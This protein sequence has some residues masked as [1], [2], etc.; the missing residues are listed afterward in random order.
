MIADA[1]AAWTTALARDV[2]VPAQHRRTV[3]DRG[4]A[5]TRRLAEALDARD[6]T[7]RETFRRLHATET[8]DDLPAL[9]ERIY[10]AFKDIMP[11]KGLGC[12]LF[13]GDGTTVETVWANSEL[14]PLQLAAGRLHAL[15]DSSLAEMRDRHTPR[16]IDDL[17]AYLSAHPRAETTRRLV[18]EGG[19][20]SL[21]APL[22]T[23]TGPFGAL[24]F[25]SDEPGAF[26]EAH[27]AVVA[28]VAD[29]VAGAIDRARQRGA[30]FRQDGVATAVMNALPANVALLDADGTVLGVNDS[31]RT[32][33]QTRGAGDP[34]GFVGR[35]YLAEC[36]AVDDAT[37]ADAR[38]VARG[39]RAV[40]NG[41]LQT[42]EQEYPCHGPA[43]EAWYKLLVKRVPAEGPDGGGARAVVMHVDI[44]ERVKAER[45]LAEVAYRDRLTGAMSRH[46]FT[47]AL[48][49]RLKA[50]GDHPASLVVLVDVKNMRDL[51]EVYGYA[52]GDRVLTSLYERLRRALG[53]DAPI[54]RVGGDEFVMAVPVD[55]AWMPRAARAAIA[56]VFSEPFDIDGLS[57]TMGGRFGY[58]RLG[59]KPRGAETMIREAEIALSQGRARHDSGWHQYTE[60]LEHALQDRVAMTAALRAALENG[61]F[62]LHF[63]PKVDLSTGEML[64]AEALLRWY[65]PQDGLISPARFI[66]VAEQSQLIAPIGTWVLDAACRSLRA[67]IDAGHQIVRVAVNVSVNQLSEGDFPDQVRA[68][69]D[70]HG[71]PPDALT[72]EIT[73][74]VFEQHSDALQDQLKTLHAMG[75]RLSLDDFGTGYSSLLYLQNYPFDEI[76][77]DK[78]FVQRMLTDPYSHQIVATV[79]GIA[80]AIGADVVAEGVESPRERDALVAM[81]CRV[82]QGFYYSIPLAEE[83]YRWVLA[84]RQRL[85]LTRSAC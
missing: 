84:T 44:T 55:H 77:I 47:E 7:L 33:G 81:G 48:N 75:V 50:S 26:T 18:A 17:P 14:G 83:D 61:E 11:V 21:T 78:G 74:S 15:A 38:A 35:N 45:D 29:A 4:D 27:A 63:Q 2:P 54:G 23:A 1:L 34:G 73:E 68:A 65:H 12:A 57:M 76:K 13:R 31:W 51:N 8:M 22:H 60:S 5:D 25:T 66:P 40:L 46:G 59:R 10:T 69:L 70:A 3:Q 79:I 71:L 43:E 37:A 52:A 62:Q 56:A 20:S 72:L 36:A 85:P 19:R 39:V 24:I 42:Y 64:A 67:W 16:I 41:D 9:L 28:V 58:T 82:A 6:S 80:R 32:F 30:D 53:A 49:A